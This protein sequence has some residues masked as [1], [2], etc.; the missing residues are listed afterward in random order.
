M[1]KFLAILL[2]VFYF[3]SSSGMVYNLHYCLD[4]IFVSVGSQENSCKICKTDKK[5]D[6]CK[7]EIKIAK[8]D[9]A[10]T[11]SILAL[12]A[13]TPVALLPENPVKHF[14]PPTFNKI[15]FSVSIN[16]PPDEIIPPLFLQY[17]NFRI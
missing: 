2:T 4:E 17:C 8:T 5:N 6:C 3:G 7:S 10:Q 12:N 11:A 1:K 15:Y 14:S 13:F 16:A 9:S